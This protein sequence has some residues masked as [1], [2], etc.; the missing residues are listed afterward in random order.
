MPRKLILEDYLC[1]LLIDELESTRGL[2]KTEDRRLMTG[3]IDEFPELYEALD[4][5]E[6]EV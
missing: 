6:N 2:S 4:G 5:G 1:G 3:V